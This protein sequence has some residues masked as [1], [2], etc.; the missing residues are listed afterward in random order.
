MS[1]FINNAFY[2]GLQ[3]ETVVASYTGI[4][5]Y[6]VFG[7]MGADY[8]Q[9]IAAYPIDSTAISY[10]TPDYLSGSNWVYTAHQQHIQTYAQFHKQSCDLLLI[11]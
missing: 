7:I 1:S 11:R 10:A 8:I 6:H 9:G 4:W 2:R 5:L 3:I